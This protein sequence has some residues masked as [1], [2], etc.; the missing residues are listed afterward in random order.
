MYHELKRA[1]RPLASTDPGYVR[2]VVEEDAFVRQMDHLVSSQMRGLSVSAWID[3]A[4]AGEPCVVL[5]FDDGCETDLIAA[6][7]ILHERGF[8]ATCYLTVDFLDTRGF[9]SRAQARELAASG[10]EIGCHS[11][12]HAFL[13]DLDDVGLAREIV[14]S[15]DCLEQICGV[16]IRSFSCPGGRFDDRVLPLALKSGYDSVTSSRAIQNAR[17]HASVLLGRVAIM[18]STDLARFGRLA[19]GHDVGEARLRDAVLARAKS[20]LGNSLYESLRAGLLRL[21]S[22]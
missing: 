13:S 5:T 12:S 7:P 19:S 14:E 1:G 15:K 17:A 18:K 20:V 3:G 11:M 9:L 21:V 8:G 22:R 2:Y 10:I 4:A 16:R 6:T